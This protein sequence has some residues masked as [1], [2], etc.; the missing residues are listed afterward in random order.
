[1]EP[2]FMT[3]GAVILL[4]MVL[5]ASVVDGSRTRAKLRLAEM[6]LN[7]GR[8]AFV[9]AQNRGDHMTRLYRQAE[10][11]RHAAV[12]QRSEVAKRANETIQRMDAAH[13]AAIR[14]LDRRLEQQAQVIMRY[15]FLTDTGT[16]DAMQAR[17]LRGTH[18]LVAKIG[19]VQEVA[20]C[21]HKV[22]AEKAVLEDVRWIEKP[23]EYSAADAAYT[24]RMAKEAAR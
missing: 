3:V 12:M 10:D 16:P 4:L 14:L 17:L 22:G 15:Q 21:G 1:M 7:E 20:P 24:K 11:A 19:F 13:A 9:R 5:C 8:Q 2:M 6:A 18:K 23:K